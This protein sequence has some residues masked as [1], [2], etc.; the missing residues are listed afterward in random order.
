MPEEDQMYRFSCVLTVCLAA[1]LFISGC[2]TR[3]TAPAR[4]MSVPE[5]VPT[6]PAPARPIVSQSRRGP[7]PA[8]V[9]PAQPADYWSRL[10]SGFAFPDPGRHG[11]IDR[12]IAGYLRHPGMLEGALARG[13]PY[14]FYISS[15]IERRGLPA[16]LALVP[17]VESEFQPFALSPGKAAGLW[18]FTP[19]TG[20]SYGLHQDWWYDGRRD[21]VA[22][23][24]AALTHLQSLHGKFN[25]DWLKALAAYN[26]GTT[27]VKRAVN[28]NRQAGLPTDFW[29]LNL[30]RETR[31]Y[32]PRLLAVRAM[33][34]RPGDFGLTLG[35]VPDEPYFVRFDIGEPINLN[36]ASELAGISEPELRA[37]NPGFNRDMTHPEGPHSLLI[38]AT[39]AGLFRTALDKL[40]DQ[41]RLPVTRYRIAAGD[42]LGAIAQRFGMSVNDLKQL[43]GLNS[44][45]I[46]TG[47]YLQIPGTADQ[48]RSLRYTVQPGDSLY[49]IARMHQVSIGDLKRWNDLD[50]KKHIHPGETLKVGVTLH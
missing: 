43:N 8:K 41:A 7:G 10:R 1:L 26:C 9:V 15:E 11:A 32:V 14:L 30:P 4:P 13:R 50:G 48:G 6:Q 36:V 25:G 3:S 28:R 23:T 42:S 17:T 46:R 33:V 16:E 19:S 45:L 31:H 24:D 44:D 37:L 47:D 5:S 34:A 29:S 49:R 20:R 18:Q 21:V 40:P 35:P 39:S 38:P 2:A 12:A 27:C 22:A